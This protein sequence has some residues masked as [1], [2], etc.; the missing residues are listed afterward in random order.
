MLL[1]CRSAWQELE[2]WGGTIGR[3]PWRLACI[4]SLCVF[5]GC[6]T[7]YTPPALTTQH[8]AHPE[9]PTAPEP[10][11]STTLAYGSADL[12]AP[13]PAFALAQREMSHGVHGTASTHA[14]SAVG[15]GKVIAVMPE[16]SQIVVD[17]K[18]IPGVMGAMTMGYTVT[19]SSLLAPLK[20]GDAIRFTLDTQ[21]QTI[22]N[23]EKLHE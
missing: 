10:P 3:V 21:T 18:D 11:P 15:E 7:A 16:K 1:Q 6:A 17:H 13:Q 23:I 2:T 9:A 12:P 20:T 19:P 8:P 22:I 14:S 4:A 5:I